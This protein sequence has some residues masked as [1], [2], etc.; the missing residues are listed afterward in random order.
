MEFS[1]I[2]ILTGKVIKGLFCV[3]F[4]LNPNHYTDREL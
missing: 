4:A 3:F 1:K 2:N